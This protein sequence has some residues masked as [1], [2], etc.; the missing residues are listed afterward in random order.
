MSDE[1]ND[2][3]TGFEEKLAKIVGKKS[4]NR[5][6]HN[7][8]ERFIS[9]VQGDDDSD[10]NENNHLRPLDDTNQSFAYESLGTHT[11]ERFT[12]QKDEA[13]FEASSILDATFDF[14]D[15]KMPTNTNTQTVNKAS[16]SD[17]DDDAFI[18]DFYDDADSSRPAV[19]VDSTLASETDDSAYEGNDNQPDILEPAIPSAIQAAPV[20]DKLASSKKPLI[21]GMIVGS[22]LIVTIVLALIYTGI[23]SASMQTAPSDSLEISRDSDSDKAAADN[24]PAVDANTVQVSPNP[25]EPPVAETQD[26]ATS[27]NPEASDTSKTAEAGSTES[28]TDNKDLS[29][30][31]A[32]TYEDFRE[33]S[34]NTLYRETND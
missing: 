34:Q 23:L 1:K 31:S 14:S 29:A 21:I 20:P 7:I 3:D 5:T 10:D 6:N 27:E 28:S 13:P 8:Y 18:F 17:I 19:A 33:E 22:L 4:R 11:F 24:A 15:Q 2:I 26:A 12:N 25:I 32:M 9:R 16:D 30:D